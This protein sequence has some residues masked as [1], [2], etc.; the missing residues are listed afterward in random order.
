MSGCEPSRS[1]H[2]HHPS[3]VHNCVCRSF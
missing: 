1:S 3:P 2:R